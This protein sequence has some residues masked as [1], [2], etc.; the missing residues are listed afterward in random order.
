MFGYLPTR[1]RLV[2]YKHSPSPLCPVC[3]LHDETDLHFLTCGG[4]AS[5]NQTLFSPFEHLCHTSQIN[6]TFEATFLTSTKMFLNGRIPP[7]SVQSEIGWIATFLGLLVKDWLPNGTNFLTKLIK[8][9]LT[10]VSARWK[11]RCAILHR[12]KQDNSEKRERLQHT[13]HSLYS[14]QNAVLQQDRQI[15]SLPL[16]HV[17]HSPTPSLQLFVTQFKPI[18][19]RSIQQQ[20][21]PLQ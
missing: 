8:I 10:A 17:L 16:Q 1:R 18:I 5:W 2:K 20:K 11:E 9:I 21:D 12:P 15:F 7:V 14:C 3:N 13:I 19:K 6:R 4:S